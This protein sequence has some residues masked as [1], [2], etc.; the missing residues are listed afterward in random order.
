V[1]HSS[2]ASNLSRP[3]VRSPN[4]KAI[5]DSRLVSSVYLL[6]FIVEHNLVG[7][8]AIVSTAMLSPLRKAH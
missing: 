5:T 4:S 6:I 8:N 7:I 1:P 3:V 2:P